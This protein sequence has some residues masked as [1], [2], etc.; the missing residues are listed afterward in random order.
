[1]GYKIEYPQDPNRKLLLE[2]FE[3]TRYLDLSNSYPATKPNQ[4]IYNDGALTVIAI[5]TGNGDISYVSIDGVRVPSSDYTD[6][7]TMYEKDENRVVTKWRHEVRIKPYVIEKL[8]IGSHR[9]AMVCSGQSY[10]TKDTVL[11]DSV[12]FKLIKR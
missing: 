7:K 8:A 5:Q 9:I 10:N 6:N 4:S 12:A 3:I 2:A 11:A 1:M